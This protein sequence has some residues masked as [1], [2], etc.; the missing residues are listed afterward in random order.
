VIWELA[1]LGDEVIG[2]HS[3]THEPSEERLKL[4]KLYLLPSGRAA[5]LARPCSDG[6]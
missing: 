1:L 3:C 2:F 4:N 5:A 6:A